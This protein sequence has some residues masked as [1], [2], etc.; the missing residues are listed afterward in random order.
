MMQIIDIHPHV[1]AA[2]QAR[3]PLEPVGG[4]LSEWAA[5]RAVTREQL[6]AGMDEAGVAQA[7]LVQAST[8]HGHDNSYT[9][10]SAA[11]HP[12]RFAW[13]GS[14]DALAPDAPDQ[15]TY[16]VQERGMAGVRLFTAGST[17]TEQASWL[18]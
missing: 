7:V 17:M 13:V 9:A 12:A 11:A 8:A 4:Q 1:I 18:G 16:W 15:I 6:L 14:V 3:Y 5:Q 2:D 10:D